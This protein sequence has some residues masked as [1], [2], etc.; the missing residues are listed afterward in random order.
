MSGN[1]LR[2]IALPG[3]RQH[4]ASKPGPFLGFILGHEGEG[5]L[6][7]A[8]KAEGLATG[9]SGGISAS[10]NSATVS[11]AGNGVSSSGA[12]Y[13][14]SGSNTL[15][16]NTNLSAAA[17]IGSAA[18]TLTL[19]QSAPSFTAQGHTQPN[20]NSFITL[21][22]ATLGRDLIFSGAG[23][24]VVNGTLLADP[25][26]VDGVITR[27]GGTVT[28]ISAGTIVQGVGGR[29]VA[30]VLTGSA[31]GSATFGTENAFILNRI[32]TV[33]DFE[34]NGAG[35]LPT[36]LGFS[37]TNGQTLFVNG[38]DA[39]G[40]TTYI[41][42]RNGDIRQVGNSVIRNTTGRFFAGDGGIGLR[43]AGAGRS[44]RV[45]GTGTQFVVDVAVTPA[46]INATN[47]FGIP[48]LIGGE[49]GFNSALLASTGSA[50]N[51]NNVSDSYIDPA[52]IS[53]S[54]KSYGIVPSGIRLPEDQ[55][56]S[57]ESDDE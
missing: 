52:V 49:G 46:Y 47:V 36:Q 34:V 8:L 44:L 24:I 23:N 4:W 42:V 6:L 26:F 43:G 32:G 29:I 40:Q 21:G 12:L 55:I 57:K 28:V 14:V 41:G 30:D 27:G 3:M 45:I 5:S 50:Q 53:A 1:A 16:A 51:S 48:L 18:G 19:G 9:L 13:N 38:I 39:T 54:F 22:D 20:D 37:I 15:N 2:D 11:I 31:V 35:R 10:N 7:S 25:V 33:S 56:E 17:R